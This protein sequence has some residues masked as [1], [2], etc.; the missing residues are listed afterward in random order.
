MYQEVSAYIWLFF[1]FKILFKC[2]RFKIDPGFYVIIIIHE[3]KNLYG[4]AGKSFCFLVMINP[5]IKPRTV[6]ELRINARYLRNNKRCQVNTQTN[7]FMFTFGNYNSPEIVVGSVNFCFAAVYISFPAI[8]VNMYRLK[9][10]SCFR[11][12][13]HLALLFHLYSFLY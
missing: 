2:L 10:G 12:R 13:L 3:I 5:T 11:L 6:N 7:T 4:V 8:R 1:T 9:R